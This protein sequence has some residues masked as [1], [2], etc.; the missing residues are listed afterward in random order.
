MYKD[1]NSSV[2]LLHGTSPRFNIGKG[3]RQ[4]CP[5][6]PYIFLLVA[7][8]LNYLVSQS[9][10]KGI[11]LLG[12]ELII[13]Q[14]ADDTTIFL[15]NADEVPIALS[16]FE[17]FSKASGLN[18][19]LKKCEILSIRKINYTE[20]CSIPVKVPVKVTY[21]GIN[22]RTSYKER[23]RDNFAPIEDAIKKKFNCWLVRDLSIYGR[24]LLS[25]AEGMS[26]ASYAFSSLYVSKSTCSQLDKSLFKFIWKNKPHKVKKIVLTNPLAEGGL[27]VLTFDV[28]NQTIK[29][30]WI[31]RYLKNVNSL[32]NTIP[33]Y[34]FQKV[35]GLN[36][37][38]KCPFSIGKLPFKLAKFH[39]QVLLCWQL[40]YKH[41]YSP[42]QCILWNNLYISHR[43]RTL[44]LNKW[45]MNNVNTVKQLLNDNG[46]FYSYEA[47][48]DTCHFEVS[49]QEFHIVINSIP[50][51]IKILAGTTLST[52]E[53]S[54]SING[55]DL[56]NQKFSNNFIRSG[57]EYITAPACKFRSVC[58]N[59]KQWNTI[60]LMPHRYI[61]TYKIKDLLYKIIH[62]YYPVK[63]KVC[64]FIPGISN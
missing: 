46:E 7:Q 50:S 11:N 49:R 42:H 24:V 2:K 3:V 56:L 60:F 58:L 53:S 52:L 30:N 22:I 63:A 29:I 26:R 23:E 34:L 14:L 32:W 21:L 8:V 1:N 36:F 47:F 13:T 15:K 43:N 55:L 16:T 35:G 40:L 64:R 25:K 5:A 28:F 9:P 18:L 48:L 6:S 61:L 27:N 17:L 62:R 44:Y 33:N 54:I 12:K 38:L 39:H 4:G 20:I 31:K 51:N 57:L 45:H 19:N 41:N 10:I 37:L 59:K